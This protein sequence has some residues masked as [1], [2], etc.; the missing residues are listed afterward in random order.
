MF[1]NRDGC[2]LYF[3]Y[4][5]LWVEKPGFFRP[6]LSPHQNHHRNPVSGSGLRNRV[7]LDHLCHP[8]KI[9][10]ETRFLVGVEKPG[11]FRPSLPPHENHHR[12]PVSGLFINLMV[13]LGAEKKFSVRLPKNSSA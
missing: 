11:F 4:Y 6:S 1:H 5:K 8:T 3:S 7:S 10:I 12:N 2:Y 9:I 13:R